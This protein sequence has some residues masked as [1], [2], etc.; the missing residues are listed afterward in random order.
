MDPEHRRE[1]EQNDLVEFITHFRELWIKHGLKSLLIILVALS[2][3]FAYRWNMDQTKLEHDRAWGDLDSATS[4]DSLRAVAKAHAVDGVAV[5]AYLRAADLSLAKA[6]GQ[7]QF[8]SSVDDERGVDDAQ[9]QEL[10]DAAQQDYQRVVDD[11]STH[12]AVRLNAMLGLAAVAEWRQQWDEARGIYEQ[13]QQ[14]AGDRYEKIAGQ[15]EV[16]AAALDRAA[17]PVMFAP[18][19]PPEETSESPDVA[20]DAPATQPA[21]SGD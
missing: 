16:R 7:G 6:L 12:I 20:A 13:V 4:P 18:E 10:L 17:M 11:P 9:R 1:L 14:L 3:L 21:E 5:H 19:P 2:G 15:A 8:I